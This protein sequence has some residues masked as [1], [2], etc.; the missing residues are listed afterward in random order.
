MADNVLELTDDNFDTEVLASDQPVLVDFWAPWCGPCK[1]IGP[2]VETLAGEYAGKVKVGKLDADD[3]PKVP[4]RFGVRSVPTVMVFKD[5]KLF[6]QA[7]GMVN[8]GKLED[9]LK[10]AIEGGASASPFVV[11]G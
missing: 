8:K 6:E 9:M 10:R 1:A 11:S 5:G 3:N 7:V 2:I 4:V